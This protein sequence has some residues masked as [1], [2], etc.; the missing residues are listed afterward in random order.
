MK[1]K[2]DLERRRRGESER[3][4]EPSWDGFQEECQKFGTT[5]IGGGSTYCFVDLRDAGGCVEGWEG[6]RWSLRSVSLC[7]ECNSPA[8]VFRENA[9]KTETTI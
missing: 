6:W 5:R 3:A 7:Y 4:Q 8:G 2:K 1:K 9:I